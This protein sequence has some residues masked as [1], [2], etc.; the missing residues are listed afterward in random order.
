MSCKACQAAVDPQAETQRK[1]DSCFTQQRARPPRYGIGAAD[2][3]TDRVVQRKCNGGCETHGSPGVSLVGGLGSPLDPRTRR[4]FETRMGRDF[5]DVRIHCGSGAASAA[6]GL[7]ARAFTM[8]RHIGFGRGEYRPTEPAGRRLLA[9]ELAHV[10]QQGAAR[11]G[12]H[13]ADFHGMAN[14]TGPAL[15]HEADH[16]AERVAAGA[17]A[18]PSLQADRSV[19]LQALP[20]SLLG[21]EYRLRAPDIPPPPLFRPGSIREAWVIP[22]PPALPELE[23]PD[24]LAVPRR[25]QQLLPNPPLTLDPALRFTPVTIIPVPRCEPDRPLTWADFPGRGVTGGFSAVTRVTTPQIIVDGNPMF[26]AQLSDRSAVLPSILG[27]GARATN[28]CAPVVTRCE[29]HMRANPGGNWTTARPNP[30]RCPA[31]QISINTATTFDECETIVGAGCDAD[32]MQESDRLLAHEQLHFDIP[33]TLVGR[34]NDALIAGTHNPAQLTTWLRDK[35]PPQQ[36]AYDGA[37]RHGCNA[38]GQATWVTNVANGL[39]AVA[40]PTPATP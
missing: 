10:V 32:A 27:L 37:S 39:P 8:G 28:A 1:Q 20:G 40:L 24:S 29:R 21:E 14:A 2:R 26:Q 11:S 5:R 15:E 19:Q 30:D 12:P 16:V 34:A 25:Q 4:F 17:K 3:H 7:G 38:A 6:S 31:T 23:V 18:S 22:A 33:C 36:R 9:H 13:P 35:I